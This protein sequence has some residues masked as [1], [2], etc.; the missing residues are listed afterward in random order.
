MPND[1]ILIGGNFTSVNGAQRNHIAKILGGGIAFS[2][3]AIASASGGQIH[4]KFSAQPG[5]SYRLESSSNLL[6]WQAVSTKVASSAVVEWTQ[7]V[8]QGTGM[9]FYRVQLVR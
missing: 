6:N 3:V 2:P 9:R 4:L 5:Q 8:A 7:S 1:D